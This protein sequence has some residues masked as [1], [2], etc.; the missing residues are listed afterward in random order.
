MSQVVRHFGRAPDELRVLYAPVQQEMD[1]VEQRLKEELTSNYPFVDHLVKH[2]FQMGGKRLRPALVLLSGRATG[3]LKD[4]HIALAAA[5]EIIHTATLVHDD[6]LDEATIRR[7][8]DTVNARWDNEASILLGDYLFAHS[9]ALATDM[10]SM[11]ACRDLVQ[12]ARVMCEGELRQMNSRGD[13]ALGEEEYIRIIGDKTAELCAC[14]CRLGSHY[15]GGNDEVVACLGRY[16]RQLGIAFQ[17]KDDLLD[18][19]GDEA[20]TGKSLGTDL[21]KEKATLPIIRLMNCLEQDQKAELAKALGR[22]DNHDVRTLRPWFA[23]TN[24]LEYCRRKAA[25]HAQQAAET[26]ENLPDSPATEALRQLTEFVVNR[27][28]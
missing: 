16:G 9:F 20:T 18:V 1:R 28:T 12:T 13:Y 5:V 27:K 10:P 7:H 21:L 22:S 19:T 11:F 3:E 23:K 6:V 25:Q 15:A 8:L 4:Q 14:C 2:G 17:I 24:A 26:L